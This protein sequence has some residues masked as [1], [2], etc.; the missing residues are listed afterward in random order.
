MAL[1]APRVSLVCTYLRVAVCGGLGLFARAGGP[2]G[3]GLK[4]L[5]FVHFQ[6]PE[7]VKHEGLGLPGLKNYFKNERKK[8][9]K[10]SVF[11]R[12]MTFSLGLAMFLTPKTKPNRAKT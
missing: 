8:R 1:A 5:N 11:A 12:R 9:V 7:H 6:G 2:W 4:S 3:Q 10:Y